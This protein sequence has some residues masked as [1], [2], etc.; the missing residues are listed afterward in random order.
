MRIKTGVQ[1]DDGGRRTLVWEHADE[2]EV[3]VMNPI[4]FVIAADLKIVG[5]KHFNTPFSAF[6]IRNQLVIHILGGVDVG[7]GRFTWGRIHGDFDLIVAGTI[8]MGA[9]DGVSV[10]L[11]SWHFYSHH[12][13]DPLDAVCKSLVTAFLPVV[14]R[15]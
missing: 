7:N 3:G 8:P 11:Q 15:L 10:M 12:H 1:R 5:S 6:K 13:D 2:N 4:E 14:G 9:L